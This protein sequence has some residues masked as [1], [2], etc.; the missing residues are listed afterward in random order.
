MNIYERHPDFAARVSTWQLL[1]ESY[2]G[3]DEYIHQGNLFQHSV[4]ENRAYLKRL[5]RAYYYNYC[6]PI[7]NIYNQFVYSAHVNRVLGDTGLEDWVENT[8]GK[9]VGGACGAD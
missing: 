9:G 6:K 7:I 4:E 5:R 2:V 3:G 8:N 1:W